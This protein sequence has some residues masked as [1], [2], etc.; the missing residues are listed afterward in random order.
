LILEVRRG[1]RQRHRA[2]I[3][4]LGFCA[5]SGAAEPPQRF[6]RVT[7]APES[8]RRFQRCCDIARVV[9]FG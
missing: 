4:A 9:G 7:A 8:L 1:T 3:V 5:F 2:Q 6:P